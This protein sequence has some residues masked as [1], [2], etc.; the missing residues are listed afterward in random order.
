[1]PGWT[2]ELEAAVKEDIGL[3]HWLMSDR[4][5]GVIVLQGD[6]LN[7]WHSSLKEETNSTENPGEGP[8]MGRSARGS[9]GCGS[10]ECG[11]HTIRCLK[12]DR[13]WIQ[14]SNFN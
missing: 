7:D 10:E 14:L 6:F 13:A 8:G 5:P 2:C 3:A 1:M 4:S 9:G 11:F 12:E